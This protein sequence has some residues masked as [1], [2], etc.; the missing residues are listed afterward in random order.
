MA[1]ND[2]RMLAAYR[3]SVGHSH[4]LLREAYRRERWFSP[5]TSA[6]D[7]WLFTGF[8]TCRV[9]DINPQIAINKRNFGSARSPIFDIRLIFMG[10]QDRTETHP[11]WTQGGQFRRIHARDTWDIC[12]NGRGEQG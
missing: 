9:P 7:N 8:D 1:D 10:Q 5:Q 11:I 2:Q 12:M 3:R 4:T 6:I